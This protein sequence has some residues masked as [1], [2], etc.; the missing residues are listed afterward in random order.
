MTAI[1]MTDLNDVICAL[2]E[3]PLKI[4]F[5]LITFTFRKYL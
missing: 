2:L 5:V 4:K 3:L 1:E